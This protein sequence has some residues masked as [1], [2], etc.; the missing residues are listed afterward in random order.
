MAPGILPRVNSPG[1]RTSRM[2]EFGLFLISLSKSAL[3]RSI[4]GFFLS[5]ILNIN[6]I[7]MLLGSQYYKACCLVATSL[8]KKKT[9]PIFVQPANDAVEFRFLIKNRN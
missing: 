1:V 4:K 8:I 7:V 3:Y 2:T 6:Q 5:K 9:R